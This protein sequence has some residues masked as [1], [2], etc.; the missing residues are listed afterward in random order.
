[1]MTTTNL[2]L[3]KD[4]VITLQIILHETK[5][6][7]SCKLEKIHAAFS[8]YHKTRDKL[9]P[10]C[11]ACQ[12]DAKT[13]YRKTLNGSLRTLLDDSKKNSKVR[14]ENGRVEAGKH[15][16]LFY[17]LENLWNVQEGKCYYSNLPMN[18]DR[19]DWKVSI[20]RLNPELG[21]TKTN[22]ALCCLE[23]NHATN[24]SFDKI[25]EMLSILDK[26]IEEN[27]VDFNIDTNKQQKAYNFFEKTIIN[28]EEYYKCSHCNT[29]KHVNQ[30]TKKINNGCKDCIIIINKKNTST[31]R[32]KLNSILAHAKSS[33]NIRSK[34]LNV[35]RESSLDIDL[36]FLVDLYN[37]QKGLCAYSGIPLQFGSYLDKN[38]GML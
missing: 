16:I 11:K 24:W 6:C 31:P 30:F 19:N 23:F 9:Q 20:E 13:A 37:K 5:V 10:V 21:Y 28:N 35:K 17:D 2:I 26:H 32:G 22:V 33:T 3:D 4:D 7:P 27:F 29:V 25:R 18:Y 14:M 34:N 8:K 36:E 1:M 12:S 38:Y 15:D